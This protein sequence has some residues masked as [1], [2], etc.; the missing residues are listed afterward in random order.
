MPDKLN[1]LK[2]QAYVINKLYN[3]SV[4]EKNIYIKFL[5]Y[6]IHIYFFIKIFNITYLLNCYKFIKIY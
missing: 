5:I 3:Q 6:K 4:L 1:A 2:L